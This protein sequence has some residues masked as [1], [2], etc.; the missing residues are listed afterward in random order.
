MSAA[1]PKRQSRAR[2]DA[3]I[4]MKER[5]S[6]LL[7]LGWLLALTTAAAAP[8]RHE[9]RPLFNGK[10][11][12]GWDTSLGPPPGSREPLGWNK[13]PRGVFTAVE[14]DGEPAVRISG[15]VYGALTTHEVFT[16]FH[17]R[18]EFKWG[19]KRWPPRANVGRDSGI[20]YCGVGEANP[21]TGWLT[22]VENNV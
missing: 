10:D 19:E 12:S 2:N 18:V 21:G 17:L 14:V 22:S 8:A 16:N 11:L 6:T 13:D 9:W 5:L 7:A 15:E 4:A 1:D 3:P 20:L